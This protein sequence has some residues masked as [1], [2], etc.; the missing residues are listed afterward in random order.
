MN[1]IDALHPLPGCPED[2]YCPDLLDERYLDMAEW[3]QA[4]VRGGI[5]L[6]PEPDICLSPPATV[7]EIQAAI[8][9]LAAEGGGCLQ[10]EPGTYILDAPLYLKDRVRLR[11]SYVDAV[12]LEIRMRGNFPGWKS[13]RI[14]LLESAIRLDNVCEAGLEHLTLIFDEGTPRI[15]GVR[16]LENPFSDREY[17]EEDTLFVNSI[18]IHRSRDCFVQFCRM[19]DSGSNPL[20]IRSSAHITVRYCEMHGAHMRS[21]GQAY[22]R[23]TGSRS[24]L[25]AGIM[26]RDLRHLSIMDG[27][28]DFPC[29][30]NVVIGCDMEVDINFHSGD[31]GHNL[32][33]DCRIRIPSWH[34]WSPFAIGVKGV[35]RPPGPGNLIYRCSAERLRFATLPRS[36][37][38]E[39]PERVYEMRDS[40]D[41]DQ[42]LLSDA[43]PAPVMGT[44]FP[45]DQARNSHL[46]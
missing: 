45:R 18:W 40:F 3:G 31:S 13:D 1:P 6:C 12:K 17:G 41:S 4:G 11:G 25:L 24:C 14:P 8:D 10:L 44:L 23:L 22:L 32:V 15:F 36:S 26:F 38:A 34:W 9:R 46:P 33:Q 30:G 29:R 39:D 2:V 37:M 7:S 16:H 21:G 43:G 19:V 5:P 28:D 42:P 20:V 35:H 27:S